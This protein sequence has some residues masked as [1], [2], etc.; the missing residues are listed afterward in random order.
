MQTRFFFKILIITILSIIFSNIKA[1]NN[2]FFS[3]DT[4]QKKEDA[5]K[6]Q[7]ILKKKISNLKKGILK[8]QKA[9]NKVLDELNK[10]DQN[11][12]RS[13]KSL[14]KLELDK[15]KIQKRLNLLKKN[16][17]E[18]QK[19]LELDFHNLK[20][21]LV[22]LNLNNL[23]IL[24]SKN[25][26]FES[27][28]DS[29]MRENTYLEYLSEKKISDIDYLIIN[30]K[31]INLNKIDFKQDKITLEKIE[32][33]EKSQKLFL[34]DEKNRKKILLSKLS[35]SLESQREEVK[36][37]VIHREKLSN[38]VN[39]LSKLIAKQK[40]IENKKK[41]R[42]SRLESEKREKEKLQEQK[43]TS[44]N[45]VKNN[46]KLFKIPIRGEI[47]AFFG[48]KR[49]EGLNWKGLFIKAAEGLK[50][51]AAASGKVV[52]ADWMRGFGNLL[53]LDHGNE[54]MTIYGNNQSIL[55]NVG[56]TVNIGEIVATV[57]NTG[58]NIQSGL[59]FE[60]RHKGKAVDPLKWIKR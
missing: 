52:F 33:K 48:K 51:R 18:L 27:S 39:R 15:N 16:E 24:N 55:K 31:N 3:K 37:L 56:E 42:L 26:F 45:L 57:G 30:I 11:I 43:I 21:L 47:I 25:L 12:L 4:I 49:V 46:D 14:R 58:G 8:T 22:K 60:I 10:S 28:I 13:K 50:I 32:I 36:T 7:L 34:E 9:K 35:K 38:L 6:E 5:K 59:Y 19:T 54:A 17:D 23:E 44:K 29:Y 1:Q 2:S 53:I 41:L 40:M 20:K